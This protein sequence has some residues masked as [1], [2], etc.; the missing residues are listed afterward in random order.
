[1][2]RYQRHNRGQNCHFA[3]GTTDTISTLL[4]YTKI[5]MIVAIGR[6]YASKNP[7]K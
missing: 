4:S 7:P 6:V 1:M 5:V 3:H 2:P